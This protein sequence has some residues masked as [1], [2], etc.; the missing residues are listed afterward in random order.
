[1][2]IPNTTDELEDLQGVEL[3]GELGFRYR[4]DKQIGG[5]GQGSVFL[6][7]RSSATGQD[8]CVIKIFRPSFVLAQPDL[9]QLVLAKEFVALARLNDRVPPTPFVVRLFETG[10]V[11]VAQRFQ[12]IKLPWLALEY[13]HGGPLGT[14]LHERVTQAISATGTALSPARFRRV[15]SAI[16]KGTMAIHEVGIVHRDLKPTN[17]LMC[18]AG[19]DELAKVSDFGIARPMG[20]ASTFGGMAVGT[21]G[22]AAPEQMDTS[23]IGPWSD[24]FSVAAIAYYAIAGEEMFQGPPMVRMANAYGGKFQPLVN[25][26]RLD[27]GWRVRRVLDR[28]ETV[29]RAATQRDL[30]ARTASMGEFWAQLEPLIADAESDGRIS[31]SLQSA[32]T[33]HDKGPYRFSVVHRPSAPL[34]LQCA[35][36]DPDGRGLGVAPSG[37][38]FFEG[39]R[40][41]PMRPPEGLDPSRI[42]TLKRLGP[43]RWLAAGDGGAAWV[44]TPAQVEIAETLLPPEYSISSVSVAMH[45]FRCVVGHRP[46]GPPLVAAGRIDAPLRAPV[47]IESARRIHAVTG[48][49]FD[50]WCLV[51]TDASGAG[52]FAT[53][54]AH[55]GQ[56]ERWPVESAPLLAAGTD[57]SGTVFAAGQGGF[58]FRKREGHPILERV[59][60]HRTFTTLDIDASD[61]VWTAAV[62]R[63]LRRPAGLDIPVWTPLWSDATWSSRFV[64]LAA[65]PGFVVAASE[66]GAVLVGRQDRKTL[67]YG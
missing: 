59:L 12:I 18:G 30:Q 45:E 33:L 47:P 64:A 58:G 2:A 13:V 15:F 26:P 52:Y 46:G 29:L 14:T 51:G 65:Y 62:G 66:D 32:T 11:E 60:S 63:V 40:W 6:A 44:F 39:S 5:G 56:V 34:M 8:S 38:Q 28:V 21:P 31:M 53:L 20:M 54:H 3:A 35:A 48:A 19:D 16:A 36:L 9:A 57:S 7:T 67:S 49:G 25:R 50:V 37:F 10:E 41:V 22:Y 4:L 55:T 23:K 27:A 17:V 1:M 24:V 61:S 42:R 43:N